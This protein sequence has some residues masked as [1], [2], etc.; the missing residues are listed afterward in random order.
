MKRSS[1]LLIVLLILEACTSPNTHRL[2]PE[3][4]FIDVGN[5]VQLFYQKLG[6][7]K[8]KIIIPLGSYLYDGLK[9]L[10]EGDERTIVF[11]DVRNRGRSS[12][13]TDSSL[14]SIW[15]DVGDL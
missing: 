7:G 3:E 15:N 10:A 9:G 14:I 4:G 12:H 11:Y 8:N 13:V 1:F 5:G 6:N 2:V